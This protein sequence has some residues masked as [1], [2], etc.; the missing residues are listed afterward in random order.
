MSVY[1]YHMIQDIGEAIKQAQKE[2]AK[3]KEEKRIEEV[4]KTVSEILS[5]LVAK[6]LNIREAM[7]TLDAC[8]STV[9]ERV[10]EQPFIYGDKSA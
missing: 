4:K 8:R 7:I 5:L 2:S 9:Q 10:G 6:E 1:W 3:I